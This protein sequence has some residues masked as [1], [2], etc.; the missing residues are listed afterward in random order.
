[1]RD[2]CWLFAMPKLRGTRTDYG[3]TGMCYGVS[4]ANPARPRSVQLLR[5]KL[6][7]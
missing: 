2:A 7:D 5:A 1:M 4:P 6:V 3:S